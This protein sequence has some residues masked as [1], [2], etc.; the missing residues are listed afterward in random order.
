VPA[1]EEKCASVG[2]RSGAWEGRAGPSSVSGTIPS[3]TSISCVG[4]EQWQRAV[5]IPN[6]FERSG[7]TVVMTWCTFPTSYRQ[8][9]MVV[10]EERELDEASDTR[11]A[12]PEDGITSTTSSPTP[13]PR[14]P[15]PS[16]SIIHCPS[17]DEVDP[18]RIIRTAVDETHALRVDR[19]HI[20]PVPCCGTVRLAP[21]ST[22]RWEWIWTGT[23]GMGVLTGIMINTVR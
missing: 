10:V 15:S 20:P 11:V 14:R 1:G 8:E 4:R 16:C 19:R 13:Y 23:V 5:C 3:V 12:P 22:R 2:I 17:I 21:T 7:S 9:M 6:A 18:D